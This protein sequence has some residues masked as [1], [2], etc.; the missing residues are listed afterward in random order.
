VNQATE[1]TQSLWMATATRPAF[2][3]L[4]QDAVADVCVVG[5]GIAGLTT[6]YLLAREGRSVIVLDDGPIAG[7]QSQ[8]TT[9]HLSNA[10]DDRFF[11]IERIHGEQ[12]SRLAAESH[13]AA[14]DRIESIVRE[15]GIDCDFTRLE[16]YLFLGEG[17][18]PDTLDRELDAAHR[19]GLSEVHFANRAPIFSFDTGRCLVFP[20]QGQFHPMKYFSGLASAISRLGG[21]IHSG[22]HVSKIEGGRPTTVTADTGA[23]VTARTVVVATNPP[24]SDRVAIHTKQAPYLTYVI[25]APIPAGSVPKSL[26]WDTLWFY[27]YIRIQPNFDGTDMLI[28]GGEDHKSGEVDDQAQRWDRLEAWARQR[29]PMMGAVA[30]RWSGMVMETTDGLAFIGPDP[31]DANVYVATGDSGMGMTH[32]TIAGMLLCDL[33]QGRENPWSK[34]YDPSRKPVWGMAWKEYLVENAD[35]ARQYVKDW[36]GGGDV[37]SEDEIFRESGAVIREGLTK[38]A[39]YR[40]KDGHLH[41]RSAVCPHLGCIVHWNGA[42]QTWDCPCHGSRFDPLGRVISGPALSPLSEKCEPTDEDYEAAV[43]SGADG[44]ERRHWTR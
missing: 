4:S 27:H 11:E 32:G 22:T 14:I 24:I 5:A 18:P 26:Y 10:I 28:V 25:S 8:R 6:A 1:K 16:G 19:A 20:R 36:L 43:S 31:G 44:G 29:F 17:D 13:S 30:H 33:I 37:S 21:K 9:A 23:T 12:A 35:V 41:R 40:D 15:E 34:L 2:A 39:V 42:E 7:G 38:V 3:P